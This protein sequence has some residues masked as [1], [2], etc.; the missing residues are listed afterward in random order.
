MNGGSSLTSAV[1]AHGS[2]MF[3]GRID[4]FMSEHLGYQ[5]DITSFAVKACAIGTAKLMRCDFFGRRDRTGIFF[6]HIFYSLNTYSAALGRI[7]ESVLMTGDRSDGSPYRKVS[8]QGIRNLV[9]KIN[10]G[11]VAAFFVRYGSRC[12]QNQYPECQAP[13]IQKHGYRFQGEGSQ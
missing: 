8:L 9:T 5:I 11:F 2:I 4:V 12:C 6:Y 1:F 10:N 3:T 7:E 13:R